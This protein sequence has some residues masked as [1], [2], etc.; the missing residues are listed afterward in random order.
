VA[1]GITNALVAAGYTADDFPVI[2]GQDCDI[3]SVQN[4]IAGTQ[5]M[6]VFKDTRTLAAQVVEMVTSIIEGSE[7]E[8][9]DEE[10]YDNGTGVIPTYLCDPVLGTA[11]NYEELLIESGYYTADELGA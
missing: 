10:N 11:D 5:S 1:N 7:P 9:N 2:T 4:M 6:S 8:I 3:T